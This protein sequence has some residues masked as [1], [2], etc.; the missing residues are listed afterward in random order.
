MTIQKAGDKFFTGL[1]QGIFKTL[2]DPEMQ[3]E[4]GV[5]SIASSGSASEVDGDGTP[6]S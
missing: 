4:G 6:S 1:S 5:P 3:K 2:K